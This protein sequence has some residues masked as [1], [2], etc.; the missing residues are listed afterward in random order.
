MRKLFF[1]LTIGAFIGTTTAQELPAPSPGC[2]IESRVGLTD[3]T[4][5]Y[6][7]P[8]V[9]GREIFG[10]LVPYDKVWRFGANKNTMVTFSTDVTIDGKELK[11]GTYSI[12][13]TPNKEEWTIAFNTD[14]EQWGAGGYTTEK[15]ALSI[16]VKPEEVKKHETFTL[17]VGNLSNKGATICMVWD[18]VKIKIPFKVKTHAIA[19]ANIEAAIKEG[20]DLDVVYYTAARYF[21]SSKNDDKTAMEYIEKSLKVKENFKCLFLQ[22]QIFEG[23]GKMKEAIDSAEKAQKLALEEKNEGWASYI[24]ETLDDWRKKK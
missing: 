17:M 7:R 10:S 1:A 12:F 3:V 18:N 14:T 19:L 8:S 9:K 22:A 24:K 23:Q 13:A 2:K 20:K 15:D 4:L 21:H 11:A 16:K 5:E 6:S